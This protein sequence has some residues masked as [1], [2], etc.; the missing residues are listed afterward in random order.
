MIIEL[1][2]VTEGVGTKTIR[3]T[4]DGVERVER[5]PAELDIDQV[6]A[7]YA[8]TFAQAGDDA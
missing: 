8:A 1:L 3:F 5:I 2:S 7:D 6:L 4:L